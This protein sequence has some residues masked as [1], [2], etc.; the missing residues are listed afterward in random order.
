MD[1]AGASSSTSVGGSSGTNSWS[2]AIG[3]T[4][5]VTTS[6]ALYANSG[7]IGGWKLNASSLYGYVSSTYCGM[8]KPAAATTKVFYAGAT[9]TTGTSAKFY[10]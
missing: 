7:N 8:Q 5:G 2:L 9:S 3:T 10:V 4:F 6:G 1:T